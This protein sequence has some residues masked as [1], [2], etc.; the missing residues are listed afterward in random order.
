[1]ENT[2]NLSKKCRTIEIYMRNILPNLVP[3]ISVSVS[4]RRTVRKL[5]VCGWSDNQKHFSQTRNTKCLNIR[6]TPKT[7]NNDKCKLQNQNLAVGW[8]IRDTYVEHK[9]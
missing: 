2:C 6:N 9:I 4:P 1:M 7:K 8:T 3:D 5:K